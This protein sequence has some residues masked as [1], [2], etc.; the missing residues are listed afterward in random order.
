MVW[1]FIFT[2]TDG[3]T[4]DML[5][6]VVCFAFF[7]IS[8]VVFL[9]LGNF[10]FLCTDFDNSFMP[11]LTTSLGHL[12]IEGLEW[13]SILQHSATF[14]YFEIALIPP[15]RLCQEAC[16]YFSQLMHLDSPRIVA[17]KNPPDGKIW[18]GAKVLW[19]HQ[20]IIICNPEMTEGSILAT[21]T[22][23]LPWITLR[24]Q[25]SSGVIFALWW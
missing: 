3:N 11:L 13:L 18:I 4:A 2:T 20:R 22:G 25:R 8:C 15:S 12:S 5:A 14:D 1:D 21:L 10:Y 23:S 19:N 7:S 16:Q 9:G 24:E 6:A 17:D